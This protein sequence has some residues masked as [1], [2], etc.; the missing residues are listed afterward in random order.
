MQSPLAWAT[1]ITAVLALQIALIVTHIPWLDEWQAL[2]IVEQSPTLAALMESLRYEGHPPLW[3]G[4]LALVGTVAPPGSVLPIAALLVA[5]PLQALILLRA[6]FPRPERVLL[7]L[8][9]IALFEYGTIARGLALGALLMLAAAAVW[10]SRWV[11]LAIA[12]LPLT[13]F[14]FGVVAIA[15]VALRWRERAIHLP[16]LVLTVVSANAAAWTVRP[17]GDGVPAEFTRAPLVELTDFLQRLGGLVVPFQTFLGRIAW[18]GFPPLLLG[19]PLGAV[20]VIWMWQRYAHDLALRAAVFGL[21]AV[22]LVVSVFV[23]PLHLRH[24]T[25]VAWMMVVLTWLA[26]SQLLREQ[27]RWRWW[28][29]IGALCGLATA[30]VALTRPFD[31]APAVAAEVDRLDDGRRPWLA[32]PSTRIPAL[33]PH[34]E[35][36]LVSPVKGCSETFVRWNHPHPI[37]TA[38]ALRRALP[39]WAETYGQSFLIL[40]KLPRG[41]PETVFRPLSATM[42]GYNG[43]SYVIGLLGPN[44]P[45]RPRTFAPCVAGLRALP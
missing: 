38:A 21:I 20:F 12:L 40:E 22:C 27:A 6:P 30:F 3:Y 33:A 37:R 17:P 11:W 8:G 42:R 35:R 19:G 44:E 15:F 14:L 16:G 9:E 29:R 34:V 1:A 36:A 39:Q 26:P 43:Q 32:F 45:I 18:D 4:L 24:L 28:L 2:L 41:V 23:Y 10:R 13:D 25:L 5:I 31:A 7:A